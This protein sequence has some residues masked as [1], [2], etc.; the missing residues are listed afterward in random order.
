MTGLDVLR[1]LVGLLLDAL[2]Y[3]VCVAFG[4]LWGL[5]IG[6]GACRRRP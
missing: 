3:L 1:G 5:T 6:L 4:F 2:P